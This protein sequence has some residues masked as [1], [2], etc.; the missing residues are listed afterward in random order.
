MQLATLIAYQ[1]QLIRFC[2]SAIGMIVGAELL[3]RVLE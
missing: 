2:V 1:R 3:L